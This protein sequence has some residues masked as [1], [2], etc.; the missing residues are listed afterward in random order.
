MLKFETDHNGGLWSTD[1]RVHIEFDRDDSGG[2]DFAYHI[3][4]YWDQGR[5]RDFERL[6]TAVSWA[7]RHDPFT[8]RT[9]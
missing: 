9:S 3:Y 5:V 2:E 8:P 4:V 6:K 7:K 1:G